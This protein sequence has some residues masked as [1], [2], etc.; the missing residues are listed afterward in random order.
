MKWL[1][2]LVLALLIGV[3]VAAIGFRVAGHDPNLWHVDPA[4]AERPGKDND[5][6]IA[7]AGATVAPTDAVF[8]TRE[9]DAEALLFQFD[10]I[11]SNAARTSVIAGSV[12]EGMITYAQRSLVFGFPDYITV[13]AL[14][15]DD[16]AGLI[17]WS[18]SR[19]GYSDMGVNR[20][21]VEIWLGRMGGF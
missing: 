1:K 15:I 19:Y 20:Q 9:V 8:A 5:F 6:L 17:V 18:R 13:K 16:R 12:S 7:P 14:K 11:A 2:W 10:S 3:V 4:V 21:R